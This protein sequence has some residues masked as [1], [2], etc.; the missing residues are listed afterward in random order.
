MKIGAYVLLKGHP[1]K[2]QSI[3]TSKAGK[4]GHAKAVV[5]GL[6]IFTDKKYEDMS[7]TSH[8]MYVPTV[9]RNE[10][11][12]LDVSDEGYLTLMLEDGTPKED[13]KVDDPELL[14][15]M[16]EDFDEG[17]DLMVTVI[18]AMGTEKILS[19]RNNVNAV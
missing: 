9:I 12:L 15:K 16:R 5:V 4:H 8:N 1:C 10:L 18:S 2:I 14:A 17:K 13:L 6:D 19:C 11:S 3:A 7:P